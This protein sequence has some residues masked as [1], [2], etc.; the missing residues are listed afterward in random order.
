MLPCEQTSLVTTRNTEKLAHWNC[1]V[2]LRLDIQL[3]YVSINRTSFDDNCTVPFLEGYLHSSYFATLIR[4]TQ[5]KWSHYVR[6]YGHQRVQP[7]VDLKEK[8]C[9]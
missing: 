8:F 5:G 9:L 1:L 3:N 2:D 4:F 6:V 7:I